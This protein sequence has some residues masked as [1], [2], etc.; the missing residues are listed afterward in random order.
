MKEKQNADRV[1]KK[2]RPRKP[3]SQQVLERRREQLRTAQKAYRTRKENT[4]TNLQDRVQELEGGIEQLSQSFLTFSNLL[5][6]TGLLRNRSHVTSALRK[7]TQQQLSLA[8]TG[9]A[10]PHELNVVNAVDATSSTATGNDERR[11]GNRARVSSNERAPSGLSSIPMEWPELM[12]L[13]TQSSLYQGQPTTPISVAMAPLAKESPIPLSSLPSHPP[14]IDLASSIEEQWTFSQYLIK[15]CCQNGYHLLVN[16]P[17]DFVKIQEVFGPSVPLA[18]RNNLISCFHAG[19][20]DKTGDLIDLM[21]TV[22]TPLRSKREDYASEELATQTEELEPA[23]ASE[24]GGWLDASGVQKFLSERGFFTQENGLPLSR[25]N[26]I[27]S[28]H[29]AA[30]VQYLATECICFGHGPAFQRQTVEAAL[31][32]AGKP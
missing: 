20:H 18:E 5:L 13:Y 8:E 21:A 3:D 11:S 17:N 29:V 12:P 26:L 30:L 4:I 16:T 27:S 7:I 24:A 25:S 23:V 31:C 9:C 28:L 1:R 2:E 22:L 6:E 15:M 19:M 14:A 32:L 10:S